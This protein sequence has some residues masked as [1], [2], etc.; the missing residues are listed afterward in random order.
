MKHK[1]ADDDLSYEDE[2][3]INAKLGIGLYDLLVLVGNDTLFLGGF[4]TA[5][6]TI[7]IYAG[8]IYYAVMS[9]LVCADS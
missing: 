4:E 9:C 3:A 7:R 6:L 1:F 2:V 5:I 8:L